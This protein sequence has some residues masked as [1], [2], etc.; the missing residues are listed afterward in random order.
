MDKTFNISEAAE[1][2]GVSVK[3]LQRWDRDGKLVANRTP[4]N[5]RYYTENQLKEI[6]LANN[7]V[8]DKMELTEYIKS[9]NCGDVI[10]IEFADE[11]VDCITKTKWFDTIIF[12]LGGLGRTGEPIIIGSFYEE[13]D[14]DADMV[15]NR[16]NKSVEEEFKI[17]NGLGKI[18]IAYNADEVFKN[19]ND[20]NFC[21]RK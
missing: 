8:E 21:Y 18:T 16:I 15:I 20:G 13:E 4:S 17:E 5:R 2:I 7:I 3:T 12:I 9:M 11:C 14:I 6:R 10:T 19:F 1:I